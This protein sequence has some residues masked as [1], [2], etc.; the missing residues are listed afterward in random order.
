MLAKV[1][2][3]ALTDLDGTLIDVEVDTSFSSLPKTIIVGRK[4]KTPLRNFISNIPKYCFEYF[5]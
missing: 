4:K 5:V 2:S 3:C 1:I